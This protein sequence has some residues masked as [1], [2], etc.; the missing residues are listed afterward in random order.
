[1]RK[2]TILTVFLTLLSWQANAQ[3]GC[4]TGIPITNGYTQLGIVTPGTGGVEDWNINPTGT[5]INASYWDDDVYL[6]EY[7]A[8][9]T[10]ES[11]SMT[12]FSRNAWYGIGIFDDCTG[13]TFSTELDAASNTT[14]ATSSVVTAAIAPGNTVYIAVGQWGTPNDLDFDVTN[15]TV[16]PILCAD[17]TALTA[18]NITATSADLGWTDNAGV[19]LWDIEWGAIGFAP[20]GTPTITGTVTNPHNLTGLTPATTY[21]FYVRADCGG[22]GTSAWVGPFSF[23]TACTVMTLP[24]SED[25]ENAGTIPNCWTM[26]GGENWLFNNAGTG[27]VGN[28]GTLS[29]TT[30]SNNYF[31]WVDASG[32]EAPATLTSPFVDISTLTVPQVS[33]YEISDNEGNANSTLDVEVWDGAA[34]NAVGTFNTNTAG[35]EKRQIVLSSLTFTG[36]A[37]VRFTF[38]ETVS[39][40]FYDDIAIDDVTFEEAPT[41]AA[42]TALNVTNVNTTSV[43]LGWTDNAG[44]SLWDIEWGTAPFVPTG[45]PNIVGTTTN[46]HNLTGLTS[47]TTYEFYV[48]AD[49]GAVN[50]TSTWT[51]PFSFTTA[52]DYCAGDPFYDN[53]GATGPYLVNSND[54]IVIC[55]TTPG[56][57]VTVTFNSFDLESCCDDLTVFN[58]NGTGGTSF[59]TFAG[60]TIPG[61]F[62]S[63]DPSGCLTFVFTSDGSVQNAGWDATITC[64]AGP[65]CAV[66]LGADTTVCSIDNITL[67]AGAG[68][69]TYVWAINGT[70]T[71]DVTQ[72]IV[73]DTAT[74]GGNGTY[75]VVVDVTDTLTSCTSTDTIVVDF[76]ICAGINNLSNNISSTVYPNPTNGMFTLNI[77]TVDVNELEIKVLNLHGQVVF[78]KNN[79]DNVSNVSEKIDLSENA[80]GIYF[81]TITSDKGVKTHKVIIQ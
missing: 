51:G 59:G 79:F 48:R 57:L 45:T 12:I 37:A 71:G 6:F 41:C 65:T 14:A 11:I 81:I 73:L 39:G 32:T 8:G 36:P 56:D 20:T 31:G 1:M 77:N 19:S 80:N 28:N 16:T 17:P 67:D 62:T 35:W 5:S 30:V 53:G 15:F 47:G 25:F 33:F 46:P 76:S 63:T 43:D 22:S 27:H 9:V 60:T 21:D 34:W 29:G 52:P 50:G 4:G 54:T 24:W 72:T 61:P 75:T 55:P 10:A 3:F 23:T 26:A 70:P 68:P 64:V 78:A 44:V 18:G 42:P 38:S 49:C 7:T 69:Y 58:G 66:N 13:T 2:I 74:L 40:D